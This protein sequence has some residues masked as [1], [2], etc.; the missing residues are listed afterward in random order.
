[1]PHIRRCQDDSIIECAIGK[2]GSEE[3]PTDALLP[4]APS[5]LDEG[6]FP[7]LWGTGITPP[8]LG[9]GPC[10]HGISN[11]IVSGTGNHQTP[12]VVFYKSGKP[13]SQAS[14]GIRMVPV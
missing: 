8:L 13:F 14:V 11:D 5:H 10:D 2:T 7:D 3:L 4:P 12:V 1:V 9:I 6:Q